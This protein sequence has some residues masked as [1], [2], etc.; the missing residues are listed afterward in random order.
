MILTCLRSLSSP[1]ALGLVVLMLFLLFLGMPLP[2]RE[3][4]HSVAQ[5]AL[6]AAEQIAVML[7]RDH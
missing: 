7:Q 4:H 3:E 5:W 2:A 1:G 6:A